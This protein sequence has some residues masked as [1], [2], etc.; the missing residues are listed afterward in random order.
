M[1]YK[2]KNLDELNIFAKKLSEKIR[3]G[4]VFSLVGDLGAGK[5]TLVQMIGSHLG[6]SEYITSPTFSLVN[7]YEGEMPLYHLDLY[8]I[9]YQ[10]E[11]EN[12]DYETYF[13]PVGVTFIEWASRV[14]DYLPKNMI[15]INITINEEN[16]V[17]EIKEDGQRSEEIA[18]GLL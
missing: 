17:L 6:I 13:Y 9:E 7:I 15:E 8:R 12:L 18:K 16:R 5:T 14:S 10:E 3:K 4:D 2:I 1:K 11:I